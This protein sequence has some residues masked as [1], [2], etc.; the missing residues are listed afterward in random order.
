[1]QATLLEQGTNLMIYGM[2]TVFV[3]LSLLVV[4]VTSMSKIIGSLLPETSDLGLSSGAAALDSS[5]HKSVDKRTMAVIQ[6][7]IDQHRRSNK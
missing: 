6:A 4:A 7:A 3:F 2:G 1:M 5:A